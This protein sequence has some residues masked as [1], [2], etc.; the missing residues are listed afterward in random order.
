MP[1]PSPRIVRLDQIL[2]WTST[3]AV[4]DNAVVCF[5]ALRESWAECPRY[6]REVTEWLYVYQ[7][8]WVRHLL[9]CAV[10]WRAD[11]RIPET[12]RDYSAF[13]WRH[14]TQ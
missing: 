1:P 9:R 3:H 13:R 8:V 10:V 5:L 14:R 7:G 6:Y 11:R 4:Y 2:P 12:R